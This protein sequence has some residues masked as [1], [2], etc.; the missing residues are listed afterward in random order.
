MDGVAAVCSVGGGCDVA[1]TDANTPHA[2]AIN[3]ITLNAP[4][5]FTI[6]GDNFG[7]DDTVVSATIGGI[8][9]VISG[10]DVSDTQIECAIEGVPLGPAQPVHVFVGGVGNAISEAGDGTPVTVESTSAIEALDVTVGSEAGGTRLVITG[11]GQK[12]LLIKL[13]AV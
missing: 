2:T 11:M 10:G 9:C 4:T 7:T 8:D 5:T 12:Y 13:N 1:I 6:T 3:P